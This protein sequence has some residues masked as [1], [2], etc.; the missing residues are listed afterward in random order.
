MEPWLGRR[1]PGDDS[2]RSRPH[3]SLALV[4]ASVTRPS[5]AVTPEDGDFRPLWKPIP[6]SIL[7]VGVGAS[8]EVGHGLHEGRRR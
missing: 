1:H 8:R 7:Q 4:A 5:V 2:P 3:A 6:A